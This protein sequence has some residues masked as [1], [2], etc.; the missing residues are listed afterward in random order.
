MRFRALVV[1][2]LLA[3]L[4]LALAACNPRGAGNGARLDAG[5][6]DPARPAP[7]TAGATASSDVAGT[8]GRQFIGAGGDVGQVLSLAGGGTCTLTGWYSN[9]APMVQVGTW[10]Q[11]GNVV[12]V[13]L[14]DNAGKPLDQAVKL[15]AVDTALVATEWDRNVWGAEPPRFARG[16]PLVGGTWHWMETV[17]PVEVIVPSDPANYTL[18]FQSDGKVLARVDCNRGSGTYKTAPGGGIELG[19]MALTR[20]ACLQGSL[21][22]QFSRQLSAARHYFWKGDTLMVDLFADSGTMKFARHP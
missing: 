21:D 4:P 3:A 15:V 8:W 17:T 1:A 2:A 13:A 16:A 11:A 22:A 7:N 10:Q 18:A 5:A 12:T 20:K 19:P 9:E 6:S 14:N